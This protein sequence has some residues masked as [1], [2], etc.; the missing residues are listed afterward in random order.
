M[1]MTIKTEA[2][3]PFPTN[4]FRG[5]LRRFSWNFTDTFVVA[6][7]NLIRYIRLPQLLVFSTIQPIM[8]VLLFAYVFGG[9][10][11]VP[12]QID[13]IN[14]LIPGIMIQTVLFGA[15]QTTV[16]LADDL[17][18]GM[19]DRFRS[20]PMA[21][22][23][24]LAGRT[25]ADSTRNVFVVLLMVGVGYLIGF[26]FQNG[27]LSAIA[28]IVLVVMFGHAFSWIS[29]FIGLITKDPETA[30]VAGFVWIFPLIF[31]SSA[32]VPVETMPD[33]LQ[34]FANVQPISRT[35]NAT[36]YLTLGNAAPGAALNDVWLTIAWMAA[37]VAVF[38]PLSIWQYRRIT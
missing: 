24:V 11:R 4:N 15:S 32:F 17:S 38:V 31:A 1:N 20:L 29:A 21:R 37:I 18:K 19:I 28:A 12:G 10:I 9:A 5:R 13:Y 22:S 30:Q 14:Y 3:P 16:G 33:W 6:R 36:R 35:I 2:R 26:R 23:A 8:F 7:R 34:A 25:L 27:F